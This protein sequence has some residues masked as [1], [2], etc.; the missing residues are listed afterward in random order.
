MIKLYCYVDET[1]QDTAG[2]L[3]LVAVVLKEAHEVDFLEKRL[4]EI[5][6]ETG[7]KQLKWK[8]ASNKIK[9]SYLKEISQLKELKQTVYYSIYRSSKEYSK[10]TSLTIAKTVLSK[11]LD[12]YSVH[13]II[14]GLNNKEREIVRSELKTLRIKYGKIRGM[15]DQQSVFLRLAD[16]MAGFLRDIAEEKLYT[17]EFV[18]SFKNSEILVEN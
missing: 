11:G 1:G 10:L 17:S 15:R 4:E 3:F 18:I 14:D 9:K 8:K 12:D 2:E 13:I 16:A 6:A 7:K 5:E